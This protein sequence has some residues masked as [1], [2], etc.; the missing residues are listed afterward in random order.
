MIK[1]LTQTR[2]GGG[3]PPAAPTLVP[4]LH[5][6]SISRGTLFLVRIMYMYM[7]IFGLSLL[8]SLDKK[9]PTRNC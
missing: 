9:L 6:P 4:A 2:L 1:N 3:M 5:V 7:N 8:R